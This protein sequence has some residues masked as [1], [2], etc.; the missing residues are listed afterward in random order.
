MWILI[1]WIHFYILF[2][3]GSQGFFLSITDSLVYN[4]LFFILGLSF[5]FAVR[6]DYFSKASAINRL[7]YHLTTILLIMVVWLGLST[8]IMRLAA[9]GRSAYFM[10]NQQSYFWR[11]V[12]GIIYY[13]LIIMMYYMAVYYHDLQE[14]LVNETRLMTIAREAELNL[15]KSQINPHF[16]FNSLNSIS[17][18]TLTAP[19]RA[20][21][22]IIKL[23]EYLRYSVNRS[24]KNISLLKNEI[25]NSSRYLEIE[26]IR[27]GDKLLF[28]I[29]IDETAKKALI[30]ALILQPLFENAVKHGVYESTDQI[31]IHIQARMINEIL[32][33]IITNNYDQQAISR[34]GEGMGLRNIRERL[35]LIFQTDLL[36]ETNKNNGIFTVHLQIP[37]KTLTT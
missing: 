22:M 13:L 27:F 32:D 36:L 4:V 37:Q 26:Q 8:T 35:K 19:Q 5:W 6:Y 18:L 28:K 15:L 14:R 10:F 31:T 17:S 24:D 33:I 29:S 2:S 34:K 1:F 21:E 12:C 30:P 9:A 7:I 16:L 23:S 20:Q 25:D 3:I 11:V